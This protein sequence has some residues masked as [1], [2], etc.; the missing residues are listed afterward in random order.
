[1]VAL[2]AEMMCYERVPIET[3]GAMAWRELHQK[4]GFAFS[5]CQKLN[6]SQKAKLETTIKEELAQLHPDDTMIF[7]NRVQMFKKGYVTLNREEILPG[8]P[9]Y[10]QARKPFLPAY[11]KLDAEDHHA[12]AFR[13][14]VACGFVAVASLAGALGGGE[15]GAAISDTRQVAYASAGIGTFLVGVCSALGVAQWYVPRSLDNHIQRREVQRGHIYEHVERAFAQQVVEY[16]NQ[17]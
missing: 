4:A 13:S 12:E 15:I 6:D 14:V 9:S 10:E 16:L 5:H 17:K 11:Q 7:L 1:M 2:T 8:L 3:K